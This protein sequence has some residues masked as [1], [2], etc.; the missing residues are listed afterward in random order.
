MAISTVLIID[1]IHARYSSIYCNKNTCSVS[2]IW[3]IIWILK[4]YSYI[5]KY[6][7]HKILNKHYAKITDNKPELEVRKMKKD[8]ARVIMIKINYIKFKINRKAKILY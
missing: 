7:D 1:V 5:N 8:G 3:G 2:Q 4:F 6:I